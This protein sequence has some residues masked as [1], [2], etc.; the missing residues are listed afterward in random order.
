MRQI[1]DY[2][3][4]LQATP[5]LRIKRIMINQGCIRLI[6][7]GGLE[8]YC[9]NFC[10][11]EKHAAF[12]AALLPARGADCI[13]HHSGQVPV[14]AQLEGFV[15]NPPIHDILVDMTSDVMTTTSK[16]TANSKTISATKAKKGP[17][18]IIGNSI[19]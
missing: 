7:R 13:E 11:G 5:L 8:E 16:H 6:Q 10:N 4:K 1:A 18:R 15:I 3:I 19:D 2:G 17:G 9:L 14:D 12:F